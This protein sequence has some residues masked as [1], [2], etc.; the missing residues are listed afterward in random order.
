VLD[1]IKEIL[2]EMGFD[3]QSN[4]KPE[5][6]RIVIFNGREEN[7]FRCAAH[8]LRREVYPEAKECPFLIRAGSEWSIEGLSR[9]LIG[10]KNFVNPNFVFLH[11]PKE[12]DFSRIVGKKY[13]ERLYA[14]REALFRCSEASPDELEIFSNIIENSSGK[15][16]AEVKRETRDFL[17][18]KRIKFPWGHGPTSEDNK[19]KIIDWLVRASENFPEEKPSE[20]QKEIIRELE[21]TPIRKL[22]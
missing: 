5:K 20:H 19:K 6:H 9:I 4:G 11:Y 22:I 2:I 1:E 3:V 17:I 14:M 18:E 12:E 15:S 10:Y 21:Y 13:L 7:N 8:R 16:V